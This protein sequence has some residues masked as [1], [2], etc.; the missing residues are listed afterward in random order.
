MIRKTTSNL[1]LTDEERKLLKKISS[2]RKEKHSIV[3][4]A[5]YILDYSNG[6]SVYSIAKKYGENHQKVEKIIKKAISYGLITSLSD[7]P[8]K[9]KKKQ[10]S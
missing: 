5:K 4:I 3:K 8:G 2:S 9:G 1:I 6:E 7:L 10:I